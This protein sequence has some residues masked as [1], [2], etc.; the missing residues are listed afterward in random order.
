MSTHH[1]RRAAWFPLVLGDQQSTP[2]GTGITCLLH[3]PPSIVVLRHLAVL[4]LAGHIMHKTPVPPERQVSSRMCYANPPMTR[5]SS[6]ITQP[7]TMA[8]HHSLPPPLASLPP[9]QLLPQEPGALLLAPVDTDLRLYE[10]KRDGAVKAATV[11]SVRFSELEV[12][13]WL[14]MYGYW[15]LN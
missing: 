11:S 9:L 14:G 1:A 6:P 15:W 12:S 5:M 13:G 10:R 2:A 4:I 8:L 3:G 7:T